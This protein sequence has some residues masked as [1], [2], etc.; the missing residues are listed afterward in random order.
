MR[1]EGGKKITTNDAECYFS[2]LK[3]GVTGSFHHALDRHLHRYCNEFSYCWNERKSSDAD[4]TAKALQQITGARL[5]FRDPL[6]KP[7]ILRR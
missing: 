6:R 5:T 1:F 2:L 7:C 4:R 3:R